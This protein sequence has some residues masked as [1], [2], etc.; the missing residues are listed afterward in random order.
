MGKASVHG[1]RGL[2]AAAGRGALVVSARDAGSGQRQRETVAL[3]DGALQV[4]R[5]GLDAQHGQFPPRF[6][7][8]LHAGRVGDGSARS[9]APPRARRTTEARGPGQHNLAGRANRRGATLFLYRAHIVSSCRVAHLWSGLAET[10]AIGKLRW[11]NQRPASERQKRKVKST[12]GQKVALNILESRHIFPQSNSSRINTARNYQRLAALGSVLTL[13]GHY[14]A[15]FFV[16]IHS[17]PAGTFSAPRAD[18]CLPLPLQ[19][20][21]TLLLSS[22]AVGQLSSSTR[23]E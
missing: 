6:Q 19:S 1:G 17:V 12:F 8:F 16:V 7:H 4:Q 15:F 21:I 5:D 10:A 9:S 20:W 23:S 22:C 3:S 14:P 11:E 2:V 18:G 13:L